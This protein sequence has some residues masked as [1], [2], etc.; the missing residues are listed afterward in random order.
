MTST[1]TVDGPQQRQEPAAASRP[2]T[3]GGGTEATPDDARRVWESMAKPTYRRVALALTQAGKP[4]TAMTVCRWHRQGWT[5]RREIGGPVPQPLAELDAVTPVLTGDALRRIES[6]KTELDLEDD[7]WTHE[8]MIA[9]GLRELASASLT[10][11]RVARLIDPVRIAENP[12]KVGVLLE[13]SGNALL[14][15]IDGLTRLQEV[16]ASV[17][18]NITP[19]TPEVDPLL[20]PQIIEARAAI[21]RSLEEDRDR[22]CREGRCADCRE[23]RCA[24][25]TRGAKINP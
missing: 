21:R 2:N 24:R 1:T 15:A 13:R 4:T 23:G 6:L 8:D 5:K 20:L 16:R 19:P 25:R 3:P 10:A 9:R 22:A 11:L 12:D 18:T 14:A 7:G 17:A